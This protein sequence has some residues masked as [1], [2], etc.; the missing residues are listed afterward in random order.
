MGLIASA[1][2]MNMHLLPFVD[3]M[4]EEY[5]GRLIARSRLVKAASTS[6][7]VAQQAVSGRI[8]N[9]VADG[10]LIEVFPRAD[11]LVTLPGGED[12][13][14]LY[15]ARGGVSDGVYDLVR[16]RPTSRGSGGVSFVLSPAGLDDLA[17]DIRE[18]FGLPTPAGAVHYVPAVERHVRE[19]DY[20]E[21]LTIMSDYHTS[22]GIGVGN[23]VIL[24]E[25][26]SVLKLKPPLTR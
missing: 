25:V 4:Q 5:P 11:W 2:R 6:L 13:P 20:K 19:E 14:S 10:R 1:Q 24:D 21:M 12:L 3:T 23:S 7:R 15:A 16:Q 18:R 26:L 8:A 17:A 22:S 9:A